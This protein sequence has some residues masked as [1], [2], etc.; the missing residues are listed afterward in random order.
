M[1]TCLLHLPS[2]LLLL[3]LDYLTADPR[4][5]SDLAAL[6]LSSWRLRTLA[7]PYLY[8]SYSN[9]KHMDKPHLFPL[10]LITRPVLAD[11]VRQIDLHVPYSGHLNPVPEDALRLLQGAIED[12]NL[13]SSLTEEYK[14]FLDFLGP[15]RI[16]TCVELSL[17][18]ASR[19]LERLDLHLKNFKGIIRPETFSLISGILFETP[20]WSGRFD[21]VRSV[22]IAF[23][24]FNRGLYDLAFVFKMPSLRHVEFT[25]CEERCLGQSLGWD[26]H[27]ELEANLG[28]WRLVRNSGVESITLRACDIG[29]CVVNVLLNCCEAVK[30]LHVEVD[31]LKSEWGLFQFFRL[32]DALCRHAKSLEHLV[33][34][35]DRKNKEKQKETGF[36]DSGALLF[37]PQLRKLRSAI[38]P[39]R[40][41]AANQDTGYVNGLLDEDNWLLDEAEIRKHLPPSP[42]RIS[43]CNDNVHYG[44]TGSLFALA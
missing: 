7:E 18:L 8:A 17:V 33:I 10:T 41:L 16:V 15:S 35:Q 5:N 21:K 22:S 29:H 39:L 11:H 3:I 37:L 42:E 9:K 34:V 25:G 30:S 24:S 40:T 23:S 4:S 28:Q 44:N 31:L 38:V 13:P 2:E 14:H 20:N 1:P 27:G 36:R 26:I 19:N 6:C 32:Q 43:I 12:M